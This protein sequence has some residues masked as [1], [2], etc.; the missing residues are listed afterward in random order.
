MAIYDKGYR[1]YE[2]GRTTAPAWWTIAQDGWSRAATSKGMRR[3]AMM[4][5]LILAGCLVYIYVTLRVGQEVFR[6]S[7]DAREFAT[8]SA[9][10]LASSQWFLVEFTTILLF[11]A[12]ALAGAGLVA[13]DHRTRALTLYLV[14]PLGRWDYVLGKALVIPGIVFILALVPGLFMWFIVGLW[15]PPGTTWEWLSANEAF[16]LRSLRYA[17]LMAASATGLLLLYGSL[18]SRR[19]AVLAATLATVVAGNPIASTGRGIDGWPGLIVGAL[20]LPRDLMR[21][22][23]VA[24]REVGGGFGGGMRDRWLPD[25]DAI[26]VVCVAL[27]VVGL[28]ALAW[29]TRHVQV[30]A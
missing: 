14:R 6:T 11:L 28:L 10:L 30:T 4:V 3:I 15:Q 12:A 5:A 18:F 21:D 9:A 23:R 27:C 26:L 19:G 16:A 7:L 2:G 22:F 13:D 29:R 25:P 1:R 17:G 20:G 24:A 8:S